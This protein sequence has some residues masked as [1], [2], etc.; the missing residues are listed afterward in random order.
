MPDSRELRAWLADE[1]L[2]LAFC[3]DPH[4]FAKLGAFREHSATQS[5]PVLWCKRCGRPDRDLGLQAMSE[6]EP[7]TQGWYSAM[8]SWSPEPCECAQPDWSSGDDA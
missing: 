2:W 4:R 7:G 5:E 1:L 8:G 3:L 6:H